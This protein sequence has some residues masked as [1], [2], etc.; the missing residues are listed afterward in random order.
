MSEISDQAAMGRMAA[1]ESDI[2]TRIDTFG[3]RL[4]AISIILGELTSLIGTKTDYG[5]IMG[6]ISSE[7]P[8][9]I[10]G[11]KIQGQGEILVNAG[12][13]AMWGPRLDSGSGVGIEGS[14]IARENAADDTIEIS[15]GTV[16]IF[17]GLGCDDLPSTTSFTVASYTAA[18][19]NNANYYVNL[20][21]SL[22]TD[23]Q[24]TITSSGISS[25]QGPSTNMVIPIASTGADGDITQKQFGNIFIYG[26]LLPY[27]GEE[28][29]VLQRESSGMAVWDYVRAV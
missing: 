8:S 5:D 2:K 19:S 6:I 9:E 14:F 17:R 23:G 24:F 22:G 18:F 15:S 28:Y 10:R 1:I 11:P 13:S 26:G 29:Q 25:S 4:D 20:E 12:A 7:I 27:G 21:Y 16:Y 3:A